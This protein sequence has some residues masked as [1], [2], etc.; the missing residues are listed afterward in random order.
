MLLAAAL[1]LLPQQS[2]PPQKK[3]SPAQSAPKPLSPSDELQ[4]TIEA[5]GNDRAA[6]VRN[7]ENFLQ[8]YPQAS[9]RPQIFRALV[10]ACLQLRDTA[11]A[12][13]YAERLVSLTPEDMSITLLAI[14]LLEK[15]GDEPA[16]HRAVNYSSRVISYVENSSDNEKSP[17]VSPEQWTAEKKRD[18]SSL[19][20]V[21]AR[22]ESK[23]HDNLSARKDT[24]ASYAL[25]PNSPAAEKLGEL[26]ELDK[27]Y[28]S[29][30]SN[31]ARAFSLSDTPAKNEHRRE[32]RQKLGNVWRLAH[33][34]DAGLGDFLLATFDEISSSSAPKTRRNAAAKDPFDFVLRKAPAGSAYPLAAQKGKILVVNFWA[35]WC[36]PCRALEPFY[37]KTASGFRDDPNVLFLSADCDDDETLVA[38]YLDEVKPLTTTVFADGLDDLFRVEAFP[39]VIVLDR[40]GKVSYRSDGFVGAP[41]VDELS[42]AVRRALSSAAGATSIPSNP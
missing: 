29:A 31:Y 24:E 41:F 30:I 25:S 2:T 16:L 26:D 28:P 35:T 27:H 8:K 4:Q 23:L 1:L 38:P 42:S 19:Y 20:L 11:K 13:S 3:T 21:R 9:E 32:L 34:S 36:G 5:A 6:L 37:E 17:R 22:L 7:L 14:Q 10:E 18:E 39:T 33:G 12:A 40:S 15:T